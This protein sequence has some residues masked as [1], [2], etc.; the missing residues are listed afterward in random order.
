M[1]KGL[2]CKELYRGERALPSDGNREKIQA[3]KGSTSGKIQVDRATVA[4]GGSRADRLQI[5]GWRDRLP[6]VR[7]QPRYRS[8]HHLLTYLFLDPHPPLPFIFCLYTYLSHMPCCKSPQ[9]L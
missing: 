6:G 2:C 7:L 8:G 5:E 3:S 1:E 4:L 9:I